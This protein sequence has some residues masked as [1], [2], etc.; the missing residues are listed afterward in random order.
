MKPARVNSE[1]AFLRRIVRLARQ[2]GWRV[3]H[4]APAR[5]GKAWRTPYA[6]DRGFPDLVLVRPPKVLFIELKAQ[7]GKPTPEQ[8]EWLTALGACSEVHACIWRE[9]DSEVIGKILSGDAL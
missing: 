7:R 2:A 8:Q 4:P 3:F 6:G 9:G 5:F 1:Q